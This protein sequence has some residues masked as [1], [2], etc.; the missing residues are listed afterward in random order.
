MM[1][2][3]EVI[4]L[5]DSRLTLLERQSPPPMLDM[6]S[7]VA[8]MLNPHLDEFNHRYEILA[9]EILDLKNVVMKLQSYTLEVNKLLFDERIRVLSDPV[10]GDLF[11]LDALETAA[12][13][14]PVAV[15]AAATEEPVAAAA[16]AALEP[17]TEEPLA[18]AAEEPLAE[19]PVAE[20]TA[21]EPLAAATAEATPLETEETT[22][23]R[24]RK[25]NAIS[26]V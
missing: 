14:E 2:L 21:E 12:A 18:A 7:M 1:T 16:A 20:A 19:E 26:L 24:R 5:T 15:A 25:K 23:M 13:T 17:L 11:K 6:E 4:A 8:N 10:H 22:S 3:Q 9:T